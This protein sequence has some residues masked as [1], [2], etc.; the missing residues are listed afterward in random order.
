MFRL[1]AILSF[2]ALL[3]GA[4]WGATTTT[5][6]TL[7]LLTGPVTSLTGSVTIAGS[8]KFN[9]GI[10]DVTGAISATAS[11]TNVSGSNLNVPFTIQTSGGNLTGTITVPVTFLLTATN[12]GTATV[13]ITG[14]TNTYANATGS[15]TNIP[16]SSSGSL[17]NG[18]AYSIGGSGSV[19]TGG[20][21]TGGGGGTGGGTGTA[22]S[23]THVW[24]SASNSNNI[25][26]GSIFIVKGTN[27]CPSGTTFYNVPRPTVGTDGVK[28]TFTPT[29]GGTGTDALLWYEYNPSGTCQLAG[30][31]PSTVATGSYNVTVT[32]GSV[33]APV[34]TTVV[35]SKFTL[36]TQDNSGSGLAT[37]QNYVSATEYDLNR[38]TTGNINGTLT[39]PAHPGQAMI[40]Y[41]TGMGPLAGGDNT[42][43]PA[44]DFS[45]HGVTVQAIVGG[46]TIPVAYA[47][48]AGYAGEDQVNFT[49]PANVPT[50]CAVSLQISVNGNLSNSTFISVAPNTG[51]SACVA[52]N[53]TTTQ[54][55]ALDNGG[56]FTVGSLVISSSTETVSG[57]SGTFASIGGG[58]IK[59]SGFQFATFANNGTSSTNTQGSCTVTTATSSGSSIVSPPAY[60][61]L[62]AG[63]LTVT[64]PSGSGLTN[65]ALTKTSNTVSDVNE[66]VYS[67]LIGSSI[68]PGAVSGNIVAGPY[69]FNGAGGADVGKFSGSINVGTPLAV[70][71]GLP[72]TV[73]RSQPLI[74]SWTGGNASDPLEIIGT[75]ASVSNGVTTST[76]FI[77]TTTAGAGT[78]TVPTSVLSQM[79]AASGA[80]AGT[81]LE[82]STGNQ[83]QLQIPLTA[84]G[85][86][87]FGIITASTGVAGTP[88]FQ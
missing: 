73:N 6:I 78:F 74:L 34:A 31:L 7:N 61:W 64:G 79:P 43:S 2:S 15:F 83:V 77:C 75:A 69:T 13:T 72:T 1:S 85:N 86:L 33:S 19:T 14:G 29:A 63:N 8:A 55:Q 26:Q 38:F 5:T 27:L 60:T 50:G 3:A 21:G 52:P 53:F 54:L 41:G 48:R 62:D 59:Y 56:S 36:F 81:L 70:T 58:F 84:G 20:S 45:T 10:P 44:Y 42:A 67:L 46:M 11:L 39:S 32:N 87:D 37:I 82:L 47:G 28:I 88:T 17:T 12:S 4:S 18:F 65:Q 40:A 49:L 16:A 68:I 80:G 23:I 51:A 57:T 66:I 71:G 9:P 25:A 35:A 24:D 22:P 76:T 30:I